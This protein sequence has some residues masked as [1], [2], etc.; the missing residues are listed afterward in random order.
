M[1]QRS[2]HSI[3][4][5]PFLIYKNLNF[6]ILHN[7]FHFFIHLT[8]QLKSK[9][10]ACIV[11]ACYSQKKGEVIILFESPA[12]QSPFIIQITLSGDFTSL[13]FP[14]QYF[15]A[16]RNTIDVFKELIGKEV[17]DVQQIENDRAFIICFQ[18]NLSLLFKMHGN[19]SNLILYQD[20][21]VLSVYNTKLV[22]D[23]S[24]NPADLSKNVNY[25]YETFLTEGSK[26]TFPTLGKNVWKFL[27]EQNIN[28][29]D[30]SEQYKW[31]MNLLK[32]FERKEFYLIKFH[33]EVILSMFKS[34][35][36]L[37][38]Y[39]DPIEAIK[40]FY[41]AHYKYNVLEKLR[42]S[43]RL[44]IQSKINQ[45]GQYFDRCSL[46]IKELEIGVSPQQTADIIM[47]NLYNI[48]PGAEQVVL[49]DFYNNTNIQIKLSGK[50]S[51]Q[52]F[53]E[54]LYKKAKRR[55]LEI[56][57]LKEH[58]Q[59][60]LQLIEQ[61]EN[62]LLK[63]EQSQSH[64]ELSDLL[65]R[66]E[67]NNQQDTIEVHEKF[68]HIEYLNYH[69]YIGRNA[70]N[71][72]L[73]TM[74]FAHKDDLWLHARDVSGSHV[75]IKHKP[76][77]NTPKPVIEKAARLA[78][79]YSERKNDSLCPVIVTEKKYVRKVKGAPKGSVKVEKEKVI[80]VVPSDV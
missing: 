70:A 79:H 19:R 49:F 51:P 17:I 78:A 73:L 27:H 32:N 67:K 16:K 9:L 12:S 11:S 48:P 35:E 38:E 63:I 66:Y 43:I 77:Q 25:S 60:K 4:D 50:E 28:L 76:G 26:K 1:L 13:N 31:I 18:S 72:D 46:T 59:S 2:I 75:I 68:K 40:G 41:E 65:N 64:K 3:L 37:K 52:K 24:L 7:S 45:A 61:C 21:K 58:Q 33:D 5:V 74:K 80:M 6:N 42:S 56:A 69:I 71:N 36:I 55:P 54:R 57:N 15:R 39:T 10:A 20:N 34:G 8:T 53:A 22:K 62:D 29:L 23:L 30:Q 44:K 47:A 14:D